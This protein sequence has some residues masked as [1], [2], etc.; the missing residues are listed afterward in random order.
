MA[1]KCF[2][3]HVICNLWLLELISLGKGN[4]LL[5]TC[6]SLSSS[7][8]PREAKGQHALSL[9]LTGSFGG[10]SLFLALVP[11]PL[12]VLVALRKVVGRELL[13]I[14]QSEILDLHELLEGCEG[15]VLCATVRL[16]MA[17][18][19]QGCRGSSFG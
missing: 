3:S 6:D 5:L 11:I 14:S 4:G 16:R 17:S 10:A 15:F 18:T 19:S 12:A 2:S 8:Y 7:F 9:I 13:K 1:N